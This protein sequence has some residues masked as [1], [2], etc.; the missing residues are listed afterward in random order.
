MNRGRTY[1]EIFPNRCHHSAYLQAE[2]Y[3]EN[4][5]TDQRS[6]QKTGR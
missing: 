2:K 5:E 1:I 3:E 4:I 6:S